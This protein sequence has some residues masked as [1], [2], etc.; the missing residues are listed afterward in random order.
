MKIRS[1]EEYTRESSTSLNPITLSP[2]P[3]FDAGS[4][5]VQ[6]R[7]RS[8]DAPCPSA[9]GLSD[10][11]RFPNLTP[12]ASEMIRRANSLTIEKDKKRLVKRALKI[13]AEF[14]ERYMKV[15]VEV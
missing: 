9:Y 15:Y 6:V 4:G 1:D 12:K 13:D 10:W 3:V 14:R 2:E 5:A 8:H 11:E 7:D